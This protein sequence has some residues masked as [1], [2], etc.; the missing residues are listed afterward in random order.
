MKNNPVFQVLV[1]SNTSA[2]AAGGKLEELAVGQLGLFNADTNLA[3]D[4]NGAFPEKFY[5]AVGLPNTAGTLGDIRKSSGEYIRKSK[6]NTA[7]SQSPV[8]EA[9]Q[10]STLD[11]T[12]FVPAANKDYVVR[13]TFMNNDS[14]Y[15]QGFN[16]PVKSFTI[17][18]GAVA[19]NLGDFCDLIA[20]EVNK[21]DEDVVVAANVGD[22]AVTFT[23]AIDAKVT[24][25]GGL[26]PKYRALR[27]YKV[28]VSIGGD[29]VPANY[30]LTVGSPTYAKG[31]GYDIQQQEYIAGG[32]IG[33]PGIYRESNLTGL[34]GYSTEVFADK[35]VNYWTLK[36]NYEF[37]SHSGGNLEYSNQFETLI[38]IPNTASYYALIAIL[39][40]A[41]NAHNPASG[42]VAAP[43]TTTTT[44]GA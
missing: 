17:T 18:T 32:W 9:A 30:T 22:T 12:G 20:A 33:N 2:L 35:A 5:F 39:V 38:A 28:T 37:L 42:S 16:H 10:V 4:P 43:V 27:P 21:D 29:F 11:L 40:D 19:P 25:L 31:S 41:I 15:M 7:Y 44:T 36:L 13:F 6:I 26:N 14:M 8:A 1:V 34:I 24:A 23:F 3:V